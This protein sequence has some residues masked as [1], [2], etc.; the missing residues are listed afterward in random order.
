MDTPL[1]DPDR[2]M[3]ADAEMRRALNAL[4]L[5]V[6]ERVAADVE[7]KV[8]AR[9]IELQSEIAE[10]R[11]LVAPIDLRIPADIN[12]PLADAEMPAKL[13]GAIAMD[14]CIYVPTFDGAAVLVVGSILLHRVEYQDSLAAVVEQKRKQFLDVI[15][16]HATSTEF[17]K[18][19]AGA[20]I[21]LENTAA[22]EDC[23][24][25]LRLKPTDPR[26]L[27]AVL[28]CAE[29]YSKVVATELPNVV[30]IAAG[31]GAPPANPYQPPMRDGRPV[32][33]LAKNL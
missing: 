11:K 18:R 28:L 23:G 31:N 10:L 27:D 14:D 13:Q 33:Y 25:K 4:Y 5:E 6:P 12:A 20:L 9:Y 16:S 15:T 29:C 22:C 17:A 26:P 21:A 7:Q 8:N 2:A 19:I 1:H 32:V 24:V 3:T 30:S